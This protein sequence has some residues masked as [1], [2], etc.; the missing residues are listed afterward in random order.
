MKQK[1]TYTCS[2]LAA[3]SKGNRAVTAELQVPEHTEDSDFWFEKFTFVWKL[4][5]QW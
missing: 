3:D 5:L 2:N 4:V 1:A